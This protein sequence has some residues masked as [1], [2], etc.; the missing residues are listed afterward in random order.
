MNKQL[1]GHYEPCFP[2]EHTMYSIRIRCRE[3]G[4]LKTSRFPEPV[5][6]D[7]WGKEKQEE[8]KEKQKEEE[9][10]TYK[11]SKV[12]G[13]SRPEWCWSKHEKER[14]KRKKS[15]GIS[16][17]Q[18]AAAENEV[19]PVKLMISTRKRCCRLSSRQMVKSRGSSNF[20]KKEWCILSTTISEMFIL[21]LL[22]TAT[23][24]L[25]ITSC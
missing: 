9:H 19:V 18:H 13:D 11:N 12:R 4:G 10:V 20:D 14:N 2:L 6:G 25:G 16:L 8:R 24:E 23:M 3:F 17:C 5:K 7:A 1:H 22:K 15:C 21:K